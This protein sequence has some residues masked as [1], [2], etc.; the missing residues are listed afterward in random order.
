[1]RW[2]TGSLALVLVTA[3]Y[4][5]TGCVTTRDIQQITDNQATIKE[6]QEQI[7]E[8][9]GKLEKDVEKAAKAAAAAEVAAKAAGRPAPPQRRAGQP[10]PAKVYAFPV[11]TSPIK[12]PKDAWV[13]IVEISEFQ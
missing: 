9:L 2:K 7:L 11:G 8:R 12:G 13:T 10:D 5:L 1:M 3:L 4:G 6:N